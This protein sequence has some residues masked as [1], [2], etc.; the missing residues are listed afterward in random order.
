M[1]RVRY[2]KQVK[3]Q[4]L[5]LIRL[6]KTYAQVHTDLAIP[7]STLSV[8]VG[9]TGKKPD[10]ARQLAHLNTARLASSIVLRRNKELRI[11]NAAFA[12][13]QLAS[14]VLINKAEVGKS[15]L[16]MLYW[17]EGGKQ[18]GNMKFTN[19][20]PTLVALFIA[21]LRKQYPVDESRFHVALQ[22]HSYHRSKDELDFWSK[23]LNIPVSQFW[24]IYRKPRGGKK[25]Y[26]RNSHG[27]C[28]VHYGSSY[29]QREL[30]ALGLRLASR[31]R[32]ENAAAVN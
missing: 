12:A 22:L 13:T 5:E 11:A 25:T 31:M 21:L 10:R 3:Q 23:T 32:L 6:G 18:D 28:N 1:A 20:D 17:A 8:W 30:I 7:K 15:L 19:T 29:I 2:S 16:A 27:I 9:K 4:A 26:R 24:K 14:L